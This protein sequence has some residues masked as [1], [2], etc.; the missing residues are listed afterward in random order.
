M[1]ALR[2]AVKTRNC[3]FHLNV[4]CCFAKNTKHFKILPGHSQTTLHC[5][6]GRRYTPDMTE[7]TVLL[8]SR[9]MFSKSVAVSTKISYRTCCKQI[10]WTLTVINS[11]PLTT[12][13]VET[14]QFAT[15]PPAFGASVGVTPFAF[16]RHFR[17]RVAL[18][19]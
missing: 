17:Y 18:F 13:C 5:Q 4:V 1:R 15:T 3:V 7:H 9:F 2:R 16:C 11:R 6:S 12:L 8:L 19:A 14:H 10:R